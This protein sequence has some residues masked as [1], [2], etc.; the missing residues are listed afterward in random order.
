MKIVIISK[1]EPPLLFPGLVAF[2]VTVK[3]VQDLEGH[4][5]ADLYVDLDFTPDK[6]R[7]KALGL[8]LPS[9]VM[10][11]SVVYTIAE[12]GY[13]FIRIN[14]WPGFL[15][16]EVHELVVSDDAMRQNIGRF[17]ESSDRVCRLSP[18]VP[19]MITPRILS[20]IINEAWYTWEAG[21]STKEE[22]DTAM[23]LG[24]N[25]PYGPFEWS[26]RLGLSEIGELLK[27]MS[28][29]NPAYTPAKSLSEAVNALKYD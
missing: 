12:I 28:N 7:I 16:R 18:D 13:P 10:V 6:S 15:E 17:Y 4:M 25:Y 24:T 2:C 22:I 5:D 21:V 9:M 29:D 27:T 3:T 11:N 19:G 20:A 26:E 8:L 1:R 14:G 23:K